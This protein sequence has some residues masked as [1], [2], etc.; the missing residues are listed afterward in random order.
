MKFRT[1]LFLSVLALVLVGVVAVFL[2]LPKSSKGSGVSFITD[3]GVDATVSGGVTGN[4][5]VLELSELTY[6]GGETPTGGDLSSWEANLEFGEGYEVI[7]TIFVSNNAGSILYVALVDNGTNVNNLTKTIKNGTETYTSGTLVMVQGRSNTTFT[8]TFRREHD[9][10]TKITYR[11]EIK[12]QSTL[13]EED[14]QNV[15]TPDETGFTYKY[16]E[17]KGE[18]SVT[19]LTSTNTQ[20]ALT[21]PSMV[22]TEG[23]MYIV[24]V[25][26]ANAFKGKNITSV[27]VPNTVKELKAS[28]FENCTSLTQVTIPNSVT[29]L[30]NKVFK[31]CTTLTSIQLPNTITS[32]GTYLFSGCT[33]LENY[34]IPTG[35]KKLSNYMFENCTKL[36][37]FNI[38]SHITTLGDYVFNG[39][40]FETLSI[41]DSITSVTENTFSGITNITEL[42][43][44]CSVTMLDN[45]SFSNIENIETAII[46][47]TGKG[48]E[49]GGNAFYRAT[50]L[51][52]VELTN[53][54]TIINRGAFY[55]CSSLINVILPDSI[56]HLNGFVFENCTSLQYAYIP[57]GINEIE[58]N[59]A[60]FSTFRNCSNLILYT[61]AETKPEG[62][63][64]YWCNKTSTTKFRVEWK[65]S[66]EKMLQIINLPK[67]YPE[68][69]FLGSC[70]T[71][72]IGASENI[73]VPE[74][75]TEITGGNSTFGEKTF[76]KS[77]QLPSTL[78]SLMTSIFNGCSGLTTVTFANNSQLT[79]IG[80]RAF[81]GCTNLTNIVMPENLQSVG[82]YAF[83]GCSSLEN[84]YLPST[85]KSVS[86]CAFA[87]FSGL[88]V[89]EF[90]EGSQIKSIAYGLFSGCSSLESV[91]IPNGVTS[92]GKLSFSG[93]TSLKSVYVPNS[94]TSISTSNLSPSLVYPFLNCDD[95]LNIYTGVS[96][97]PDN[98]STRWNYKSSSASLTVYWN[99]T[100]EE[101][102]AD[103]ATGKQLNTGNSEFIYNGTKLIKYTGN[104]ANVVVPD[105]TKIIT[106][107]T[108]VFKNKSEIETIKFPN[109]ITFVYGSA[110]AGCTG[111][112]KVVTPSIEDW[113]KI[114]FG[115]STANPLNYAHKLY[116][117]NGSEEEQLT[118]VVIPDTI[119]NIK[120]NAFIGLSSLTSVS[121]LNGVT[122]IGSSAF[123]GCTGLTSVT[124]PSS[125]TSIGYEA[126]ANCSGLTKVVTPSIEDWLKISFT[127]NANPLCYAHKLYV[128][129]GTEEELVTNL[130]IPNS[131]TT[132]KAYVFDGC[133]S[134][135]S[136]TIPEGV[137]SIGMYA[138]RGCSG[139]TSVTIPSS[140]TSIGSDAF[141]N[142]SGLT[143]VVTS[144]I[145]G[146]LSISF[147]NSS[148]ANPLNYA[149]HLYIGEEEVIELT[150]PNT[151][152]EIKAYAFYGCSGL[153]NVTISEGVTSIG[154]FA[155]SGCTGLTSVTIPSSVTSIGNIAFDGCGG[156]TKVVT[157]SIEDWLEIS[158]WDYTA[159]PLYYAHH[160]YIGEEEVTDL[161][162]PN[163]ITEIKARAFYGCTGLTS[164]TIPSSITSIGDSAFYKC[165]GLT[166]VTIPSS[167][168]SIVGAVFFGCSGL[169][170]ITIPEGVTSI[171][172]D[173]FRGCSGLTSVIIPNS[174]TSIA[175]RAFYDCGG[176]TSVTIPSSVTSIGNYAFDNCTNLKTVTIDSA[177]IYKA[178]VGTS[179]NH[180][181]NLL[182]SATTINVL[183]SVV[184]D[185]ANTNTFLN[186]TSKYTKSEKTEIDGK[187]Y[188]VYT[189]IV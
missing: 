151:I 129:N 173:A 54:I 98:W 170:S 3:S 12:L 48:S 113:L 65:C 141:K 149:H 143:G 62:W 13:T 76:I 174:V 108:E 78:K 112:T 182:S 179:Y 40:S 188:Y 110:F 33:K 49:L 20:T 55:Y 74:L 90:D 156:L 17:A 178:A 19:G 136:V 67:D 2:F 140:V 11:Y 88:K 142:C 162:I 31:G 111:L 187:E 172:S 126:F 87:D 34:N 107:S 75:V 47:A 96:S 89:F 68:F 145:E 45:V 72:Y 30:G 144:S 21:I 122:S 106:S 104:S 135:T 70:I 185:E 115:D 181:G 131:I 148:Y 153:T 71:S 93:C 97:R 103:V 29:K 50:S 183:A 95:N 180:A 130:V 63:G 73:I 15:E 147:S 121:I 186:D 58:A 22:A 176:L 127:S 10:A 114:S 133:T 79:S 57:S 42:T 28:V 171:G 118:Q 159:N 167:V 36:T 14:L 134:I 27:V 61:D 60:S 86:D 83:S 4:A 117:L 52:N 91:I 157:S 152:T 169:T 155:F 81:N 53:G 105:G 82:K 59:I 26:E 1:K 8:I 51:K 77:V 100:V 44:P 23:K 132:I 164:V 177:N 69:T 146:W 125:V 109:T 120:A 94:V 124:I 139:L 25:I 85:V 175:Y 138:F 150:I 43:I 161:T 184:D 35:I 163:T 137:T 66:V 189:K 6:S 119:T 165:S 128:T 166:S 102:K 123:Y 18:A 9:V 64:E 7:L 168:T 39:L 92:I 5:S 154:S 101:M 24:T 158:F 80:E 56:E 32:V 41:P 16:D 160:L 84:F 46:S 116:I 38:P 99:F 37:T